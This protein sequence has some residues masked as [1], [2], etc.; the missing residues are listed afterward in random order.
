MSSLEC[1]G[2]PAESSRDCDCAVFPSGRF[3][4]CSDTVFVAPSLHINQNLPPA[5][6]LGSLSRQRGSPLGGISNRMLRVDFGSGQQGSCRLEDAVKARIEGVTR[7][8]SGVVA[9]TV[10]VYWSGHERGRVSSSLCSVVRYA[11]VGRLRFCGHLG[12]WPSRIPSGR[13]R[14]SAAGLML[15]VPPVMLVV[16]PLCVES[17]LLC[18]DSNFSRT[19]EL[20]SCRLDLSAEP[21]SST[22]C[23]APCRPTFC[24]VSNRRIRH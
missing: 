5:C 1:G 9:V 2:S 7:F 13:L 8:C 23:P 3:I 4:S 12:Q 22:P 15:G 11:S 14:L 10:V 18:V 6:R 19:A 17:L 16:P 20:L 24:I 21:L